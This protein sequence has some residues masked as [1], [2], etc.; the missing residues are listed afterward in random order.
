MAI[1]KK[2]TADVGAVTE[3]AE[4]LRV[5]KGTLDMFLL[6][7]TPIIFNRM[8][9][10]INRELL[11]PRKKTAI[12]R[13]T[14]LKHRPIEEFQASPYRVGDETFP[15]LL[16]HLATA[17]KGAMMSAAIDLGAKRAQ[18]GRWVT[19]KG[20][21]VGIYG[22]PQLLMSVVRS[23]DMNRTPDIRS[24]AIV[25]DWC[26][27]VSVEYTKPMMRPQAVANLMAGAGVIA[28]VGDWRTE[29]GKGS[30]GQFEIV[31]E[32]D[33]RYR[34]IVKAGGRKAQAEA[35]KNPTAYDDETS[36][37][38]SWFEQELADRKLK[39]SVAA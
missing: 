11:M 29:K 12:D 3:V 34:A 21:M 24:R 18:I 4:V 9:E 6:G 28:G 37:L 10:K 19:V 13:A 20:D 26:C 35:M 33:P 23:A 25:R 36:A 32:D 1:G 2:K 27:R 39:G 17:F 30:Y 16:A 14:N 7:T 22:V 5:E 31:G 38:L 15:T 8:S